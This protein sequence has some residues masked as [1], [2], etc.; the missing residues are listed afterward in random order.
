MPAKAKGQI[1]FK[2]LHQMCF[3]TPQMCFKHPPPTLSR[4]TSGM[5]K[6]GRPVAIDSTGMLQLKELLKVCTVDEFVVYHIWGSEYGKR[7]CAKNRMETGYFSEDRSVIM[8]CKG[9]D[10]RFAG[11]VVLDFIKVWST[12]PPLPPPPACRPSAVFSPICLRNHRRP[13][14]SP[15]FKHSRSQKI[16]AVNG[17][18]YPE[19]MGTMTVV[20]APMLFSTLWGVISKFIDPVTREKFNIVGS[21]KKKVREERQQCNFPFHV[22]SIFPCFPQ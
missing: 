1:C 10:R 4:H 14:S 3:T 13:S 11:K 6:C 2:A 15:V 22:D 12:H 18:N 19:T 20:N 5:D 16:G 21:N 17:N 7:V 9:A 8:D